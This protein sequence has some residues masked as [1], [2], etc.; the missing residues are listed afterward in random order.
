MVSIP[1]AADLHNVPRRSLLALPVT[2]KG[3]AL[4][5]LVMFNPPREEDF[6]A[7]DK[8]LAETTRTPELLRTGVSHYQ[9][10]EDARAVRTEEASMIARVTFPPGS[11]R[12]HYARTGRLSGHVDVWAPIQD[13]LPNAEV[14]E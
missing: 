7:M 1:R 3:I 12:V 2:K 13:F 5:R 6:E 14:V 9:T 4:Y 8:A 11:E 10:I